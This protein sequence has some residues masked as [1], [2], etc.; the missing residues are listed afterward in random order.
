MYKELYNS[1]RPVGPETGEPDPAGATSA[2]D[3]MQ[4]LRELHIW[5]GKPSMRELEVRSGGHRVGWFAGVRVGAA[6]ST[7]R[8]ATEGVAKA[9][10]ARSWI[11][12]TSSHE[13]PAPASFSFRKYCGADSCCR[14]RR[15]FVRLRGA[16]LSARSA[17][18]STDLCPPVLLP[19]RP[20]S[21]TWSR[22]LSV[23]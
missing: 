20:E 15:N 10:A 7:S 18:G 14:P 8:G 23:R 5:A 16:Q 6:A 11:S 21:A 3:Y 1:L 2:R 19:A 13:R 22:G 4:A 17:R 12:C 9:R